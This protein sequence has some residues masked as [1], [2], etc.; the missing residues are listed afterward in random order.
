ME[1]RLSQQKNSQRNGIR[2]QDKAFIGQEKTEQAKPVIFKE[3]AKTY[4]QLEEVTTLASFVGR[5]HS[6]E[7]HLI[8]F[9]GGKLLSEIKPQDVETFRAQRK[10]KDG[11]PASVQTINHD[12]IALKHCLNV[13]IRRG[14][15]QSNPASRIPMPN[16]NN[17]RDRILTEDEWSKLYQ[18]AKAHIRPVLLTANQLGQRFSEIVNLTWDRVDMKRG[19]IMLRA[20]DT[21]TKS[22]RQVPMTPDIK[23]ALQRL[24]KMRRLSTRHVFTY[25]GEP[26]KRISRSFKTA[27]KEAGIINFRFHDLRHCAS[28]N[29]RRAGVDTATAM[30]IVGHKSEKMWKRYNA[31]RNVI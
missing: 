7:M 24:A 3:W 14:L 22:A 5:S 12:H 18:K 26:L 6:I 17:E 27:L 25:K 23:V 20:L 11:K 10:K 8:P 2:H 15:I 1:S 30:K 29:L 28:T 13:A 9:F 21:K 31:I 16:A 19:F 4:L